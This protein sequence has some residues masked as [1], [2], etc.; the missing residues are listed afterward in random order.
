[1]ICG[2]GGVIGI[3]IGYGGTHLL[4]MLL[5]RALSEELSLYP[6]PTITLGAFAFSVSLGIIFGMY[7]AIKASGLQ[8][9]VALRA[10]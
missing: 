7:P 6:S 3:A 9:V 10:E 8:P 1:M 4:G 5:G 2:I